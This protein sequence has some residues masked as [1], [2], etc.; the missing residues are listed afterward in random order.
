MN[1]R[2]LIREVPV[3]STSGNLDVDIS[4][5]TA[6]SRLVKKGALFV[7]IP[8]TQKDG[9]QFVG[10]AVQKGAAAIVLSGAPR[11]SAA[12]NTPTVEVEDPRAALALIAA[13]FYG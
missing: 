5:V 10:Q 9:T 4:M 13:N 3:R 7:A 8:G 1:L 12:N 11:S 6:D 2:D